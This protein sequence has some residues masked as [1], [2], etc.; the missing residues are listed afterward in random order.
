MTFISSL[1]S[2]IL[3]DPSGQS[4]Q[5]THTQYVPGLCKTF[6]EKLSPRC[7]RWEDR[8]HLC[9]CVTRFSLGFQWPSARDALPPP[10]AIWIH[11]GENEGEGDERWL[12]PNS[13]FHC[14]YDTV[15]AIKAGVL[16]KLHLLLSYLSLHREIA[17]C[18]LTTHL[19]FWKLSAALC[20]K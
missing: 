1:M 9:D 18:H 8:H 2:S 10:S 13:E 16:W 15:I 4:R 14:V 7:R 19:T 20:H 3:E 17:F 5:C 12:S 6:S 11:R